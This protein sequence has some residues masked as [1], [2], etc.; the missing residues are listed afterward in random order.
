MVGIAG[1]WRE[2]YEVVAMDSEAAIGRCRNLIS[3]TQSGR[4]W[5]DEEIL[6]LGGGKTLMWVKGHSGVEGNERADARAKDAVSKG[7]WFSTPSL[8]TPAGIRQAY[9]LYERPMH[10]K[11]NRDELRGLTYLHM[12]RGPMKA[13][14]HK[15][16]RADNGLCSCGGV[17]NAAHLMESG[18]VKG[19]RRK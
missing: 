6:E 15:I 14:L 13:W 12:D 18:C 3:G 4:S 8:A 19:K 1:A 16:K 7:Q 17:Q 10:L 9:P 11:W 5:I 2:G